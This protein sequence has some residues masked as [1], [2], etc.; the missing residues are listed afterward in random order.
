MAVQPYLFFEGRCEEALGFY[1]KA[2]GA[3]LEMKMLYSESP[4]ACPQGMPPGFEKKV[5]HSAFHIGDSLVMASDGMCSGQPSFKGISLSVEAQDEADAKR[6]FNA[7]SEG[8]QV[9]MPLGKTFFSPAF[10]VVADKFGL[11]WM[12]MVPQ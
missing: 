7:L 12:V 5:M 2:L 8:G 3:R 9:Q 11:S 6:K 4:E 1:N 10:G